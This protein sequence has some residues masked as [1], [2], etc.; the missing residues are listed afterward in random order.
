M[1]YHDAHPTDASRQ[2][3]I[4]GLEHPLGRSKLPQHLHM[5]ND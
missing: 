5:T 2:A 1:R 3:V 4:P